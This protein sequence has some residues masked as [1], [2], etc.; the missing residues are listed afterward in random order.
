MSESIVHFVETI[1]LLP[2]MIFGLQYLL[3]VN[4]WTIYI[5]S[6]KGEVICKIFQYLPSLGVTYMITYID[7]HNMIRVFVNDKFHSAICRLNQPDQYY[8]TIGTNNGQFQ[9]T[10]DEFMDKLPAELRDICAYIT[11]HPYLNIFFNK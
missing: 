2:V 4:N 1:R 11:I 10:V 8:I 3:L 5:R 7:A 6:G 9:T